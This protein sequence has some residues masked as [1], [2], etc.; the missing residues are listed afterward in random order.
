MSI[1]CKFNKFERTPACAV[2]WS[3]APSNCWQFPRLRPSLLRCFVCPSASLFVPSIVCFFLFVPR[4]SVHSPVCSSIRSDICS[5][6]SPSMAPHESPANGPSVGT[7]QNTVRNDKGEESQDRRDQRGLDPLLAGILWASKPSGLP[8]TQPPF[9]LGS[10][11]L[12]GRRNC[13]GVDK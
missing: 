13:G 2:D 9:W 1:L 4:S 7:E 10:V 12:L 8:G 3:P 5:L 11:G 6:V